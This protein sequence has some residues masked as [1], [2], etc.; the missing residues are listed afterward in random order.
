MKSFQESIV[1]SDRFDISCLPIEIGL[2]VEH[3][4]S[5]QAPQYRPVIR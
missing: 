4:N 3:Q 2:R 5:D 1:E